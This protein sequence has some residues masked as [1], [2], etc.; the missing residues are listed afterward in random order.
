MKAGKM[1]YN[2]PIVKYLMI[3]K[4]LQS[5]PLET[6]GISPATHAP[7]WSPAHGWISLRG[8]LQMLL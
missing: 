7:T 1:G 8:A 3:Q 5:G 6:D 4:L 2:L